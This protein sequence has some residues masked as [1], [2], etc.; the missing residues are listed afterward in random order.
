MTSPIKENEDIYSRAERTSQN[1]P[2]GGGIPKIENEAVS[3]HGERDILPL[4]SEVENE[5]NRGGFDLT[6][7][8]IS[9]KPTYDTEVQRRNKLY[10]EHTRGGFDVNNENIPCGGDTVQRE[11]KYRGGL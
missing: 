5:Q 9:G 1:A 6:D 7:E 11:E 2:R 10:V 3:M 4:H 8:I